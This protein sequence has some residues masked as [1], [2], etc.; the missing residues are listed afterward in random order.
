MR[1]KKIP[2]W[3]KAARAADGRRAAGDDWLARSLSKAG[4]LPH[5]EAEQAVAAGRVKLN[6]KVIKSPYASIP[7]DSVVHL[8]GRLVSL[9]AKTLVLAF[10]KPAGAV[11]APKDPEGQQTVFD[12]LQ[13]ALPAELRG[14]GW[15]AVGRLDRDTT[16][17]LLFTNDP[18]LVSHVTAPQ[19]HLP[20]RYVAQVH[21]TPTAAKLKQLQEG[22]VLDDGPTRPASAV[23]R[24]EGVIELTLTEGRHHQVKRML[25]AVGLPVHKLHR[26]A[27]GELVLDLPEG[28]LR[29]LSSEE[30]QHKLGFELAAPQ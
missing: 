25:G 9:E 30:I 29:L 17:L 10:H 1:S 19:T 20:K 11:T 4:L 14:Y 24:G 2:R 27:I 7:K 23:L 13:A 26:E 21:G 6:G 15:H 16:G 22:L 18:R 12:L 28:A 8:D 5:N 3:L